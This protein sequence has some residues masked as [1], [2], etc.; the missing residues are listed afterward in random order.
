MKKIYEFLSSMVVTAILL[1]IFALSIAVATFIEND[2]G[3]ETA[4]VEIYRAKW[5]ELLLTTITINLLLSFFRYKMH[6]FKKWYISL[7]HLSFIIV[8]LG[9]WTTRYFGFEGTMHIREGD[10][11]NYI[12][13]DTQYLDIDIDGKNVVSIPK[14]FSNLSKNHFS[15]SNDEVE[16]SLREYIPYATY[17]VVPA[18]DGKGD[19]Y[20]SFMATLG[21]GLAPIQRELHIGEFYDLGFYILDFDS[22]A[23]PQPHH[24]GIIRLIRDGDKLILSSDENISGFSMDTR[25]TTQFGKRTEAKKR[26]LYTIGTISIVFRDIAVGVERKLVSNLDKPKNMRERF[27]SAYIFDVQVGEEKGEITIFGQKGTIGKGGTLEVGGKEITIRYGSKPIYLPFAIQ[28]RDFQLERYAGSMSP[29]SYASEV[30]VID[31]E[32]NTTFDYRIYMNHVLD[33]RGYRFFQSSY[34]PDELGTILSVNYDKA[35]TTITYIGYAIMF[36]SMFISFFGSKSRFQKLRREL[37]KISTIFLLFLYFAPQQGKAE[38]IEIEDIGTI[39]KFDREHA[40]KFGT[41]LVQ[42]SRGRMKPLDTLNM[43]IVNKIHRSDSIEGLNYNQIVLGMVARPNLWK[44]VNMIYVNDEKIN[45]IL[46]LPQNQKYASF[47]DFFE[48]ANNLLGYKLSKYVETASRTPQKYRGKFEKNILKVDERV[49]ITYMVYSGEILRIFP[50]PND[51]NHKWVSPLEALQTFDKK[52]ADEVRIALVGYLQ[53]VDL[54]LQTGNWSYANKGLIGI[55]NFQRKYG[56]DVFPNTIQLAGEVLYNKLQI[57]KNLI[58]FVFLTGIALL[59]IGFL[60]IFKGKKRFAKIVVTLKTIATLILVAYTIGLLLRWF[61]SGHAPW[62]DAY[63]S[64]VYI[65]W[66]S[67]IAGFLFSKSS[68]FI[69]GSTSILTGVILFVAHL[70]WLDPQITNL[71]PVLKSYWLT[72]HV[73][74]ITASYGFLGLSAV[75]GFIV[76]ILFAITTEKSRETI[77][78]R[79]RE[80]NIVNEMNL[81]IGLLMLTV[82][83]FLGGVW[84]NESWGRY[85]GWDPKETWALVT[86]LVYAVVVHMKYIPKIYTPYSFALAS[87]LAFSSVLMTYFG[88]NFYLSGM[89]SYAQGDPVPIPTFVYYSIATIAVIALLA[90]RKRDIKM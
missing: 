63:E 22:N 48:D 15:Y 74:L 3:T 84:A 4:L 82:G 85:W 25:E 53:A 60:R 47:Q 49:N 18:S 81:I 10:S 79:I 42:D 76:L 50:K 26:M 89:H 30:T 43:E 31:S 39:F 55:S 51:E 66:A 71:V 73:S 64:L 77:G 13:S 29:S 68:P 38:K 9:A 87:L 86:I 35:G 5:F 14:L 11:S 1:L 21:E 72:I 44:Q 40:D 34:D 56:I 37:I 32:K 17:Q 27:P 52:I 36:I 46:G 2:Y 23:T 8:A 80:L 61:I 6:Y 20:I 58:P 67:L 16:I 83:N 19:S 70:N 54:S 41:L 78:V 33:Y 69:M 45:K 28:L 62:S 88:V 90:Y 59:G 57:F 75:L 12:L 7:F 65:G 24:K